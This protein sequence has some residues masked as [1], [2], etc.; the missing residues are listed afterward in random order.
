[1]TIKVLVT[2]AFSTGK[3][4]LVRALGP[5][6]AERGLAVLTL[7]DAS[8]SCPFPLNAGQTDEASIWIATTQVLRELESAVASPDVVLCDRGIPDLLAH[9]EDLN[10]SGRGGLVETMRPFLERWCCSYDLVLAT[11]VDPSVPPEA[12]GLRLADPAYRARLSECAEAVLARFAA[13]V[14]LSHDPDARIA[15]ALDV[16]RL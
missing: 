14:W 12:D 16:I 4:T 1:M 7:E 11:R 6:L 9:Q 2:G 8:R 15:Q 10:A 5:A 13:P 3:T